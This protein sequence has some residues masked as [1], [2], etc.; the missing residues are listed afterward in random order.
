MTVF[1]KIQREVYQIS[2]RGN[3]RSFFTRDAAISNLSK[4]VTK[5]VFK[6]AGIVYRP[7]TKIDGQ[8]SKFW[9]NPPTAQFLRAE[10]RCLRRIK[11]LL[12]KRQQQTLQ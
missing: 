7:I 8:P 4:W 5:K 9:I 12:N 2:Y 3:R 10:A 11:K 6:R 1:G